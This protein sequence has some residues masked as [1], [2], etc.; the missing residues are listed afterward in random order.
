MA[1]GDRRTGHERIDHKFNFP[2][3]DYDAPGT[4]FQREPLFLLMQS[5]K[6]HR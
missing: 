1:S 6:L 3:F 2:Q 5:D 4:L